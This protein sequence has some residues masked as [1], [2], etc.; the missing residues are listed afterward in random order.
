MWL[1]LLDEKVE[2]RGTHVE[3]YVENIPEIFAVKQMSLIFA[4]LQFSGTDSLYGP[5][6]HAAT[7]FI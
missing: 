5:C 3:I 1:H 4:S 2:H 7:L 6:S